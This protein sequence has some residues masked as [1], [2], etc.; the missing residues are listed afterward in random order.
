MK[1]NSKPANVA[2]SS[3]KSELPNPFSIF[4][5][6]Q[7][8][9]RNQIEIIKLVRFYLTKNIQYIKPF[10]LGSYLLLSY[11]LKTSHTDN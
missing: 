7:S 3:Y 4:D 6:K 1:L 9:A 11:L 5:F 2:K 8:I 10:Y